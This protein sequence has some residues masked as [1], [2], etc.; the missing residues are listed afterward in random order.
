MLAQDAVLNVAQ[1]GRRIVLPVTF[2]GSLRF[3]MQ[4]YQNAMAIVRS[5]GIPDVFLTFT[6]NLS[7]PEIQSELLE[8]QTAADRPDLVA[9]VLQTKVKK[10]L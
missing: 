4:A 5:L 2:H 7:W 10:L 8:G 1:V 6:C 3:M 9:Q